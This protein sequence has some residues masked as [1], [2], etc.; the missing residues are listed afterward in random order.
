MQ[1]KI[2]FADDKSINLLSRVAKAAKVDCKFVVI[3]SHPD[4]T[5]LRD[6]MAQQTK[7]EVD[8]FQHVEPEDPRSQVGA[9][10]FSSG[11]TG[12]P[13]GTMLSYDSLVKHRMEYM[14]LKQ[15][16]RALWYSSLSWITGTNFAT[17]CLRMRVTRM[18]HDNF[19]VDETSKVIQNH[20][21]NYVFFTPS[22]LTQLCKSKVYERYDF[23]LL[24]AFMVGGSNLSKVVLE[25]TRKAIPHT[26]V[27]NSYG[28]TLFKS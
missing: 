21:V 28:N 16:M 17:T 13:K 18:I 27:S 3:R 1:P 14:H 2:V 20:K 15:G 8:G 25:G 9:I 26:L 5:S 24:E 19:H 11:T 10:F 22:M 23:S 12:D 6:L 4:F 7:E